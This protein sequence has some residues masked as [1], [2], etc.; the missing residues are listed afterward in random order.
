MTDD[1]LDQRV[2]ERLLSEEVDTSRIAA[3]V[4]S[5]IRQ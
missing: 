2:R 1:E 3:A 4:R 5:R